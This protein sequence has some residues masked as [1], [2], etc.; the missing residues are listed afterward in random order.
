[1]KND[2]SLFIIDNESRSCELY[3]RGGFEVIALE[4]CYTIECLGNRY[5]YTIYDNREMKVL[6]K[7]NVSKWS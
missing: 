3:D 7:H 6:H 2:F 5:G 4:R 1:M